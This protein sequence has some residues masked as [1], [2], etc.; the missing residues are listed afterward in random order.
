MNTINENVQIFYLKKY[1]NRCEILE[2]KST[3]NAFLTQIL[4]SKLSY[5]LC[6]VLSLFFFSNFCFL[7]YFSGSYKRYINTYAYTLGMQEIKFVFVLC[8]YFPYVFLIIEYLIFL[9]FSGI[10]DVS[11]ASHIFVTLYII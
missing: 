9:L 8:Y 4:L 10:F 7:G 11:L 2:M 5:N 1:M 3:T 6:S